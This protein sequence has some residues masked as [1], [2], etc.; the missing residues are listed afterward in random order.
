MESFVFASSNDIEARDL[1]S[2]VRFVG[3]AGDFYEVVLA[4]KNELKILF[5]LLGMSLPE[6]SMLN[7]SEDFFSVLDCSSFSFPELS[8]DEFDV[9]YDEWID[10][11]GRKSDMDEY[12]QLIFIQGQAAKWN[13]NNK[14]FVLRAK[15]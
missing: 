10:K 6:E 8:A 2:L 5:S 3:K 4:D 15:P 7:D 14:R 1:N 9:F 13:K 12:G 11:T